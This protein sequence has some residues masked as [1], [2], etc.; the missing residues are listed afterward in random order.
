MKSETGLELIR[1]RKRIITLDDA[2]LER[3]VR[4][5]LIFLAILLGLLHTWAGATSH[6]MNADG[7]SYLDIGDAYWRG[8]WE[9]ALNPTW[10]PLYSWILGGVLRIFQPGLDWEFPLVHLSNFAIYLLALAAFAFYWRSLERTREQI[11]PSDKLLPP[12][13][14]TGF[15]YALFIWSS[16][17]MIKIWAVTPDMLMTAIV[18]LV[19]GVFVK[20]RSGTTSIVHYLLF[21]I[22]LGIGYLAKTIMFPVAL[23]LLLAVLGVKTRPASHI[24]RVITAFST[25][26]L[27]SL[28][29]IALISANVGHITIGESGSLTFVRYVNGVPY[30][31]WQGLPEGSGMP[32]HPSRLIHTDPP[33]YEF[34]TSIPGT[35]PIGYDPSYWYA[36]VQARYDLSALTGSLVD[37]SLF[38]FDLFFRQLGIVTFGVILLYLA[39][40]LTQYRLINL[41]RRYSLALVSS[42][43]FALY[44]LVYVEGRYVAVFT[45]LLIGDLLAGLGVPKPF[46]PK[47]RVAIISTVM[48]LAILANIFVFNL[49]GFGDLRARQASISINANEYPAPDWP[50][51]VASTL[52]ESGLQPGDKVG[53]IGYAFDSYWAR[54]ARLQIA[55]EMF[56]WEATPFYLGDATYQQQVIQAFQTS[57]VRAIVA[58]GVPG[59]AR[60]PGWFQ[61]GD[62]NT[63]YYR[64]ESE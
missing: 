9:A 4:L 48:F 60:L 22:L 12:W 2:V 15:G 36:G 11:Y 64:L 55:T 14:W 10:S 44:A 40:H 13:A 17:V 20:I 43:V 6:S 47:G 7:I 56:E 35:Y 39:S 52:L 3:W 37:S 53:V 8:D 23:L 19:A 57:G 31:H 21:G 38:Y 26:L 45:V 46:I 49:E 54:L 50:G 41:A 32:L 59:Y 51:I 24:P 29:Y 42:A 16:L 27:L 62:T 28:P 5:G 61:V 18:Y 34:G 33:I 1:I 25:F 30:P 58:E 63:F